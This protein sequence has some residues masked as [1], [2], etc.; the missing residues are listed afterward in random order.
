MSQLKLI[1]YSKTA[2]RTTN[3][4]E[5]R[6]ICEANKL[7]LLNELKKLRKQQTR[8]ASLWCAE[9]PRSC[10]H[11]DKLT[12]SS[13]KDRKGKKMKQTEIRQIATIK[14]MINL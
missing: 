14:A 13:A 2:L 3:T 4:T 11:N 7:K 12:A 10:Y 6:W 5:S 1:R 9:Y 8:Q